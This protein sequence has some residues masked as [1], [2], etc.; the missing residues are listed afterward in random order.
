MAPFIAMYT[1]LWHNMVIILIN[2]YLW[3]GVKENLPH[4]KNWSPWQDFIKPNNGNVSEVV[5]F[6]FL[7]PMMRVW[8]V[9]EFNM[10]ANTT[11]TTLVL[12]LSVGLRIL[13][14]VVCHEHQWSIFKYIV[15]IYDNHCHRSHYFLSSFNFG[16]YKVEARFNIHKNWIK[17]TI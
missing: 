7:L 4:I 9:G 11:S 12:L 14:C 1:P 15:H 2:V 10:V 3:L 16:I 17:H 6:H 13:I 5:T 8:R